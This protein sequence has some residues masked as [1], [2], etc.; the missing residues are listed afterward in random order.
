MISS[1]Q[2]TFDKQNSSVYTPKFENFFDSWTLIS[3]YPVIHVQMLNS[4]RIRLTQE[5]F[6]YDRSLITDKIR[7]R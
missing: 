6:I 7:D 4:T 1:F 3:G 2:N 5:Y